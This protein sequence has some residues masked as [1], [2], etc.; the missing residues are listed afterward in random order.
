MNV[1]STIHLIVIIELFIWAMRCDLHV[2]T[3]NS[4]M[5]G[6]PLLSRI[7]RESYNDPQAVYETLKRRGMNL[8]TVT[9]H[10]S[11][12]AVESLR[13]FPDFFLSEEVTCTTP[14]GTEIHVGVYGIEERHHREL[15]R[16]RADLF[17]LAAYLNEQKLF[18]SVNHVFSTLTGRRTDLDFVF[19]EQL[20]TGF[21][22]INGHI[23]ALGNRYARELA[24]RWRKAE[25]GG[26]D[27]HTLAPLAQTYTEVPAATNIATY[28]DGLRR[29][30]SRVRGNSG[31]YFTLTAAVIEIGLQAIREKKWAAVLAP[32]LI[33]LPFVTLCNYFGELIFAKK[34][35]RRIMD[36]DRLADGVAGGLLTDDG[37]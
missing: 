36:I 20:F 30:L 28:L 21:E 26:S 8:V 2:H 18:S 25:V 32:L 16:R 14:C 12:D 11:I 10:D 5:C 15:Q 1:F 4:G 19:L 24:R 27:S 34:W 37:L 9:D 3:R 35:A 33:A 31:G 6:V 23:P 13:R 22:T 17:S 29:G 7:C